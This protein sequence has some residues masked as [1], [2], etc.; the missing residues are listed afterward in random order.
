MI[1]PPQQLT[2][3]T[4]SLVFFLSEI[5]LLLR[6][7]SGGTASSRDG[8]SLRRLWITIVVSITLGIFCAFNAPAANSQLLRSLW[9][10]A[11]GVFTAGV[12]LRWYAIFYL[13]RFF[14]VNVAI[15]ADHRVVD[16]GPY[17][18]VRHPSY[19]GCLMCFVG[20]GIFSGNWLSLF[21]M[22]VPPTWVFI[23]RIRIEEAALR[24]AL[25]TD[26]A[27]YCARTPRLLPF[28]Y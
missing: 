1:S 26:Y 11:V 15:A 2:L 7:R 14:T 20:L 28:V 18:Y 17:R 10:V 22:C 21:L 16:S 24:A 13:G 4:L 12:I 8:G 6:R 3:Q 9:R 23:H 25:G 27:A 19:T 5:G